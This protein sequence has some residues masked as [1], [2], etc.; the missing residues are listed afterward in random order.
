MTTADL[1]IERLLAWGVDTIFGFTGDGIDGLFESLRT[2]Q[3]KIKFIQN[4]H[5]EA[6]AFAASGDAA[7]RRRSDQR[8]LQSGH[9]GRSRPQDADAGAG[10]YA[11]EMT[12]R[13]QP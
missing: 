13:C 4:R 9:P 1:L 12:G 3:D 6:S 7:A 2:R 5:E 8:R 10:G 11:L